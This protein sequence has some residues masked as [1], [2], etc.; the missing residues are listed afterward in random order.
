V[1][2]EADAG[3]L[4][5]GAE[6]LGS[7]GV[8]HLGAVV[9]LRVAQEELDVGCLPRLRLG[10]RVRLLDVGSQRDTAHLAIVGT[11]TDSASGAGR[12]QAVRMDAVVLVVMILL[13]VAI[14]AAALMIVGVALDKRKTG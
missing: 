14:A 4:R 10:D 2:V 13:L 3:R 7:A 11:R 9:A 8:S 1:D 12:W 6:A 5:V